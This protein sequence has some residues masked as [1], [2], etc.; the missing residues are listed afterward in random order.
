MALPS[1]IPLSF[2]LLVGS[3]VFG[4]AGLVWLLPYSIPAPDTWTIVLLLLTVTLG[5]TGVVGLAV[6]PGPE[7]TYVANPTDDCSDAPY[8]YEYDELSQQEQE[9]FDSTLENSPYTTG[10]NPGFVVETDAGQ[11]NCIDK[12]P[13]SYR[14]TVQ[15]Y[16]PDNSRD[17]ALYFGMALAAA[18][19]SLIILYTYFERE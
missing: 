1:P 8:A 9:V 6:Q 19:L 13:N 14:L 2:L 16:E 4:L 17:V 10:S 11:E 7:Y 18:V 5:V 3:V 12:G 15:K